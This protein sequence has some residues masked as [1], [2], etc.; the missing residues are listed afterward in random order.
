MTTSHPVVFFGTEE[1]SAPTLRALID[2]GYRIAYVVTKPDTARGRS[3]QLI[4]PTVKR[5]ALEHNIPVL[6]P[7]KLIDI[8]TEL[9][10]LDDPVGILVS[11]G[12]ILPKRTLDVFAPLGIINIHPSRLPRYRGP[13]PIEAAI[14]NG[15]N[16]TAISI[17]SLTEGMDEGPVFV[18]QAVKLT[19]S[20]T[21][22]KLYDQLAHRGA[23]LLIQSLPQILSGAI[24]AIPQKND[25]VSYTSLLRKENGNID[26]TTETADEI[27][28]KVRA[29]LGYP[30]SHVTLNNDD[31][32]ITSAQSS[33]SDTSSVPTLSCKDGRYVHIL[34]LIAKNGKRMSGE[35]YLRGY[36]R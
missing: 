11:Y 29:H 24:R 1:F 2:A 14:L 36:H 4:A 15:D 19:G 28:R 32:I 12:K 31:V 18:Q 20:E 23:E 26:P 22:P 33:S 25:D 30:K 3:K 7:Q 16:E 35:D 21:K 27:E 17:M 34:E 13:A 6:Q 10:K 8:Q 9:E 5:I